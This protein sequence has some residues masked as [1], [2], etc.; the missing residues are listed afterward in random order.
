MS[1]PQT[2]FIGISALLARNMAGR[3]KHEAGNLC[4][5]NSDLNHKTV[6]YHRI[7]GWT[8][9]LKFQVRS[10][11]DG[12]VCMITGF[13]GEGG[14]GLFCYIINLLLAHHLSFITPL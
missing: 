3:L 11:V 12:S 14:S 4:N 2:C 9:R 8:Y 7:D 6:P 10:L 13:H 1:Y 5:Y